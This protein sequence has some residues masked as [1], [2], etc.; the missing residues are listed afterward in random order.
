MADIG[1]EN[2]S[3]MVSEARARNMIR[4]GIDRDHG[5]AAPGDCPWEVQL[6]TARDALGCA[7]RL[8]SWETV[9]EAYELL[10]VLVKQLGAP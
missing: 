1:Y 6:T 10:D 8:E 5:M 7:V 2:F 4:D 3:R 9:A